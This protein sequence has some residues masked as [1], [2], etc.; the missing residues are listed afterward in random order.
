MEAVIVASIGAIGVVLA[1][2]IQSV[3]KE[4]KKDHGIVAQSLD[5]I[6]SKIDNHIDWHLEKK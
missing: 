4:N 3:R 1:A 6:E 2:L 5:R